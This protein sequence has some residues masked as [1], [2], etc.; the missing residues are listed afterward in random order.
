MPN[1]MTGIIK[2]I[3]KGAAIL[4]AA[5]VLLSLAVSCDTGSKTDVPDATKILSS[6]AEESLKA[7]LA[8]FVKGYPVAVNGKWEYDCLYDEEQKTLV[9]I[10]GAENIKTEITIDEEGSEI[11]WAEIYNDGKAVF[12]LNEDGKLIW[13]D[14]I[15]DEGAGLAFEKIGWFQGV[16][17]AGED[18]ESRYELNCYWDVEE[19]TEG[20][21]YSGYK[22]EIIRHENETSTFWSYACAY[23]AET[24]TLES[25]LGVKEFSGEEGEPFTV[26]YED[27]A[28]V[29]FFND[30]GCIIWQD[31]NENAGE[32]LQFNATNG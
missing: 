12:S 6:Q 1:D 24:D 26:V 18:L 31:E 20:E 30:E 10:D 14:E 7:F 2:K 16:W 3:K 19:P 23:N 8:R 27:G 21:V 9:S 4:L 32:G 17:V 5:S 22:V 13:K 28:A 15:K 11:D 29:F 25:A